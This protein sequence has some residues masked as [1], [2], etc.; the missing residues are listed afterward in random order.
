MFV[1]VGTEEFRV[2]FVHSAHDQRTSRNAVASPGGLRQFVDNL[3]ASLRRRVTLAEIA[4]VERI[5]VGGDGDVRPSFVPLS[6]GFAVCHFIDQFNKA[7]GRERAFLRALSALNAPASVKD[8][9]SE[10]V[11]GST[12]AELAAKLSNTF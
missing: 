3:A 7:H 10:A 5:P 6:Q 11:T 9:L 12:R 2:Q 1:S 8:T 4:R